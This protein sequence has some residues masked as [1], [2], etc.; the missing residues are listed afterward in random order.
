MAGLAT[1][2]TGS[3]A[4]VGVLVMILGSCNIST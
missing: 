4:I 3:A 2:I 1:L